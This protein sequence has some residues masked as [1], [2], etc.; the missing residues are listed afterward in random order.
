MRLRIGLAM[1]TLTLLVPSSAFGA[2]ITVSTNSDS[3]SGSL[4][5]AI[6]S[7]GTGDTINFASALAGKTITLMSGELLITHDLTITGLGASSLTVSGNNS[8]RVFDVNDPGGTV[9]ISGLT[10]TAGRGPSSGNQDGGAILVQ[11]GTFGLTNATVSASKTVGTGNT[12]NTCPGPCGAGGGISNDSTSTTTLTNVTVSGDST[13]PTEPC[14]GVAGESSGALVI[15][16]G[17]ISGN[18]SG[19]GGGVCAQ[20]GGDLTILRSTISGNT[21]E[22][23][24]GSPSILAEGGGVVEDGG[25]TS[26]T[27]SSITDNT[28]YGNGGAIA[29]DG[30]GNVTVSGSSLNGNTARSVSGS[31]VE[32]GPHYP[33]P[34][35]TVSNGSGGGVSQDGGGGVYLGADS[36]SDNHAD[37]FGGGA[38]AALAGGFDVNTST[39]YA[40]TTTGIVGGIGTGGGFEAEQV[41][42]ESDTIDSNSGSFASNLGVNGSGNTIG[43]HNTIVRGTAPNCGAGSGG[44]ITSAGNNLDTGSSCGFTSTGD[45][46]NTAP[47]LGA[48]TGTPL[49]EPELL[50]SPTIDA[51]APKAACGV[52]AELG[53]TDRGVAHPTV[54][55]E[56]GAPRPDNGESV[57]D[58]G[59]YEFQ[60][61]SP[62]PTTPPHGTTISAAKVNKHKHR[63]TFKFTAS[64]T[65]TG[66]QCALV[67]SKK[68]KG[69]HHKK[70]KLVF[71]SCSSP[72]TYKHLKHGRYTFE[73]RAFNSAGPDPTPAVKRFKI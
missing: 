47:K 48:P 26:I 72:K 60:D 2:T 49:Y 73:V 43:V 63:A 28:V 24:Q 45:L 11:A 31:C 9:S 25:F 6:L 12:N 55:D 21:A 41:I 39:I 4:R 54:T 19:Y 44:T 1:A 18:S 62:T 46:Q 53:D 32:A 17:A 65:V 71:S 15:S 8:S 52:I 51:G 23:V 29:E 22:G 33:T 36:I 16:G 69:K 42:L 64:G 5:Q 7:S 61:S 34:C 38:G 14:G 58:M 56:R 70:P 10:I 37:G 3:G 40:N 13:D 57:C 50:G 59:A 35:A 66:F 20:G 27:G 67:K 68:K 30:G